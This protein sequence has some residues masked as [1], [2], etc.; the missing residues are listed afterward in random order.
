[1]TLINM[2]SCYYRY[3]S[4]VFIFYFIFTLPSLSFP[5]LFC[6]GFVFV[7]NPLSQVI[8]DQHLLSGSPEPWIL[9]PSIFSPFLSIFF[10]F[11]S[12]P[13]LTYS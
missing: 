2:R 13:S 12:L 1:M 4:Y 11:F 3:Y 8:W 9:S 7:V 6:F 5:V 10:F